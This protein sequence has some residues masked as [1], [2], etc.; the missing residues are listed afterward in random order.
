MKV[1]RHIA[2]ILFATLGL[3]F[4]LSAGGQLVSPDSEIPLWLTG[5]LFVVLGL[6]PLGGA[7]LLLRPT[8]TAPSKP[9]PQCGGNEHKAAA[10]LKRSHNRW[11]FHLGGWLLSLLWGASRGTQVRCAQCD[12]LYVTDTRASRIGGV[13]LWIFLLLVLGGLIEILSE[14]RR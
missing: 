6:L 11:L 10:S 12:T 8:L 5:I 1:L 13:L 14:A 2:G 7:F 9:C 3:I 4:V